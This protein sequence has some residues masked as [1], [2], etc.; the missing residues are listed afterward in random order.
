MA[1]PQNFLRA[2]QDVCAGLA[3]LHHD[4]MI[5]R[6]LACRNLF[7]G[8]DYR[9][10]IADYGLSRKLPQGE[11]R[12]Y[13]VDSKLPWQWSAPEVLRFRKYDKQADVWSLGVTLWEILTKGAHPYGVSAFDAQVL[14]AIS[15]GRLRLVP[16]KQCPKEIKESVLDACFS[17]REERPSAVT[18]LE[19]I[20]KLLDAFSAAKENASGSSDH[21]LQRKPSMP[22]EYWKPK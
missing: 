1:S 17:P 12:Y 11:S 2:A 13:I 6:D 5:H 19:S 21:G 22:Y 20:R 7:M 8:S 16:P 15:S 10:V 14:E 3:H 9:I 18:L 4:N